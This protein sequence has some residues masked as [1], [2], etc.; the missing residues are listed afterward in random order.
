MYY[1]VN[2]AGTSPYYVLYVLKFI[3]A[4]F[5][6]RALWEKRI[7]APRSGALENLGC[8]LMG[9]GRQIRGRGHGATDPSYFP[10]ALERAMAS[11][12][13]S[14]AFTPTLGRLW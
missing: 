10:G 3:M 4:R 12:S 5:F 2:T 14:M 13:R 7:P 8:V 11:A 9:L 1:E 6:S